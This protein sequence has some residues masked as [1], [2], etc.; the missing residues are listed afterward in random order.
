MQPIQG[1]IEIGSHEELKEYFEWS[2][3]FT[4]TE[5]DVEQ[6]LQGADAEKIKYPI[7]LE[8]N[9]AGETVK[10]LAQKNPRKTVELKNRVQPEGEDL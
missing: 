2:E 3:G 10:R 5:E 8:I 7:E 6:G 4:M 9:L 1:I